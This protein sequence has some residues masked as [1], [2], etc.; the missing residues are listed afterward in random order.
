[1]RPVFLVAFALLLA[2]SASAQQ[3]FSSAGE[4]MNYISDQYRE[5]T[6]DYWSYA[7]AVGHGKSARKVENRRQA[8]IKTVQETQKKITALPAWENDKSLRDSTKTFLQ[9][10]YYVL[11]ED[12]GKIINLED[13]AE[14]SYDGMEAYLLAQDLA[15]KK[16]DEALES[17]NTTQRA[18]AAAHNVTMGEGNDDELSKKVKES[19][20]V[21]DYY[22][23]AYLIFFKSFKQEAY[24]LDAISSKNVNG[25]EQNKGTLLKYSN[26]AIAK[27]DTMKAFQ[28]DHTLI[29]ACRQMQDFYK[30]E[31][32]EKGS[33]YTNYFLKA[34]NFDKTKKAIEAQTTR[35]KE[36]VDKYN[37]SV[38]DMNK[39][40]NDFNT[41]NNELFQ[42]RKTLLDNWNKAAQTF[43]DKHTP[44]YR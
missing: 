16:L 15:N 27:L 37:A 26:E 31:C 10:S 8:L 30:K 44:K 21:N 33:V 38:N 7:A 18:F 2:A 41:T 22:K 28:G 35:S 34:E 29:T 42:N 12:Y 39:A 1:M 40:T 9:K 19:S 6:K 17:L 23:M 20:K 3:K 24:M 25:I 11:T 5:I 4:Y 43:L 14:Q 13:V 36:D 32:N